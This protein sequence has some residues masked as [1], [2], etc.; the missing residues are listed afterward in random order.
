MM[1][2]HILPLGCLTVTCCLLIVCAVSWVS[3]GREKQTVGSRLSP[4]IKCKSLTCAPGSQPAAP[5][6]AAAAPD[7]AVPQIEP[8]ETAVAAKPEPSVHTPEKAPVEPVVAQLRQQLPPVE[9]EVHQP[10]AD[11]GYTQVIALEL[12]V[13]ASIERLPVSG[14]IVRH[15]KCSRRQIASIIQLTS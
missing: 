10:R 3:T 12:I 9:Q 15:T 14:G 6:A 1:S 4:V 2:N 7:E 13:V 8:Q 5:V 11:S